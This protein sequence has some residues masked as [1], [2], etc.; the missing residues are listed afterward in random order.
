MREQ[1][2]LSDVVEGTNP[3][4]PTKLF[5]QCME[6]DRIREALKIWRA[7]SAVIAKELVVDGYSSRT[8]EEMFHHTIERYYYL[9]KKRSGERAALDFLDKVDRAS[10]VY[11]FDKMVRP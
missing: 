1:K 2:E 9:L 10:L 6:T 3:L 8:R 5:V 11:H 7:Q 4:V